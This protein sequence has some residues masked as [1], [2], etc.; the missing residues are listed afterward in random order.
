MLIRGNDM[1]NA[2]LIASILLLALLCASLAYWALKLIRPAERPLAAPQQ[3]RQEINLDAAAGLFGGRPGAAVATNYQL[4]GVID[5]KSEADSV[6]IIAASGKPAQAVVVGG[7]VSPGVTVKEVH[8]NYVLL[9]EN[10][11]S[12]RIEL[13]D[14]MPPSTPPASLV[15]TSPGAPAQP[16]QGAQQPA[17]APNQPALPPAKVYPPASQSP[18]QPAVPQPA[19]PAQPGAGGQPAQN[20]Q[21]AGATRRARR[22]ANAAQQANVRPS[23]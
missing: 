22:T 14:K 11:V 7:E 17:A 20:V 3:T 18:A 19:Q 5:A 16:L 4:R 12:K 23:M 13:P 1:K 21:P 10:G 6:A 8:P 2:R 15:G 9:S